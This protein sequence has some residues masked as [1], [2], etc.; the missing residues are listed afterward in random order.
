MR[1]TSLRA[2]ASRSR[3]LTLFAVTTNCAK[4]GVDELLIERQIEARRA[5]SDEVDEMIDLRTIRQRAFEAL[6][7]A[8]RRAERCPFRQAQVDQ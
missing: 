1:S 6:H 5:R 7:L 2:V 4:F 8:Q 3:S